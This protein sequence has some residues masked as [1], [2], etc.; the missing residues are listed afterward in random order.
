[1]AIFDCFFFK[2]YIDIVKI[3]SLCLRTRVTWLVTQCLIIAKSRIVYPVVFRLKL[4]E[5][6]LLE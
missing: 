5:K 4:V 1:M 2:F 6:K 3:I